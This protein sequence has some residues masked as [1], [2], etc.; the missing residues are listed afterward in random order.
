MVNWASMYSNACNV[1]KYIPRRHVISNLLILF[2]ILFSSIV[3]CLHVTVTPEDRSR[4]VFRRGIFIGLNVC[5]CEGGHIC[6]ISMF[7]LVL[8]WK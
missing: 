8:L 2:F 5:T 3:W 1:E 7:G 4:I 6:P